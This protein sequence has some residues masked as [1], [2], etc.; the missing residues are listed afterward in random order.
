[1]FVVILLEDVSFII[2][3]I[4][5]VVS[6]PKFKIT[7]SIFS[8]EFCDY[9]QMLLSRLSLTCS[10]SDVTKPTL[11]MFKIDFISTDKSKFLNWLI[12]QINRLLQQKQSLHVTLFL[13]QKR[14][15]KCKYLSIN[16]SKHFLM[17]PPVFCFSF[18]WK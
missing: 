8:R 17:N 3:N 7:V 11:S 4:P 6:R 10:W 13:G 18:D 14:L 2:N 12:Q 16:R 5:L 1:V 9:R 15:T